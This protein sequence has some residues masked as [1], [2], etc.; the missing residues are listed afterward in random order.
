MLLPQAPEHNWSV[1]E[2]LALQ[3][4]IIS[5]FH[6]LRIWAKRK[7][8]NTR[9]SK[10]SLTFQGEKALEPGDSRHPGQESN[11]VI[12][13]DNLQI[14]KTM[15]T[16]R[17]KITCRTI[18]A[19]WVNTAAGVA[20]L[21]V[22]AVELHQRRWSCRSQSRWGSWRRSSL[23]HTWTVHADGHSLFPTM[24]TGVHTR[25]LGFLQCLLSAGQ[26]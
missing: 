6:F 17:H 22:A 10:I 2:L 23:T 25:T 12:T 1:L 8:S 11:I 16:I 13:Q 18:Q 26:I 5:H 4:D 9:L 3:I 20:L 15:I 7:L 21:E 24:Q 19:S 14:T